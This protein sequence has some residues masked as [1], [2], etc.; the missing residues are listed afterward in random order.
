MMVALMLPG[1]LL[2][3]LLA[4][5]LML[6]DAFHEKLG[7]SQA[8][9]AGFAKAQGDVITMDADLQDSPEEIPVY[10]MITN[11]NYDLV[12]GWKK[13][14]LRVVAKTFRL[15]YLIGQPENIWSTLND[16]NCGLKAYKIL[17]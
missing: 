15:N 10:T 5:I 12:S 17:W 2:S 7:K 16:F 9:H 8:L 3:S 13:K 1:L 11:Q 4:T 6:R 14:R